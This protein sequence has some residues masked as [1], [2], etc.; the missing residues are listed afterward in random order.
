[1]LRTLLFIGLS[2]ACPLAAGTQPP[3]LDSIS[4]TR[5]SLNRLELVERSTPTAALLPE[6]K[7]RLPLS[8][9]LYLKPS[10]QLDAL[11]SALQKAAAAVRRRVAPGSK[12]KDL[13]RDSNLVAAAARAYLDEVLPVHPELDLGALPTTDWRLAWPKASVILKGGQA[14]QDGRACVETALLRALK[15]PARTAWARGHLTPQYWVALPTPKAV[16]GAK[17]GA[18]KPPLGFWALSDPALTDLDVEAWSLDA[19]VLSRLHWDPAQELQVTRSG[20]QRM[21]FAESGTAKAALAQAEATGLAG[22]SVSADTSAPGTYYVLS[23]ERWTLQTEGAM[24]PMGVIDFLCPYRAH[25]GD[26]GR[27]LTGPVKMLEQEGQ[28]L[29]SDRPVRLRLTK[30]KTHDEWQSPPPALGVLH[31]QSFGVRRPASVLQAARSVSEV[32][33]VLLR[34]DNLTPRAGWAIQMGQRSFLTPEDG[35][36]N[37]TLTAEEQAAPWL[38]LKVDKDDQQLLP[39]PQGEISTK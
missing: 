39:M 13:L 6:K 9:Q 2:A 26:K 18:P 32:A 7:D 34:E 36:F 3:V 37:V 35:H 31:Y 29:W 27:E 22:V 38:E 10:G 16:K 23:S 15:I 11:Q 5:F 24:A 33:G 30:G 21:F 28:A 8:V 12:Q 1:M 14:D 20:W 4:F 25:L 19:G 17:K